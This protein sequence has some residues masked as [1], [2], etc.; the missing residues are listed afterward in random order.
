[1]KGVFSTIRKLSLA[2]S[3]TVVKVV[4]AFASLRVKGQRVG[5]RQRGFCFQ[6]CFQLSQ[7]SPLISIAMV[8]SV[9]SCSSFLFLQL[10]LLAYNATLT[11]T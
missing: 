1:M 10:K 8:L 7:V 3:T 5:V 9:G 6:G 2:G 4:A 11:P